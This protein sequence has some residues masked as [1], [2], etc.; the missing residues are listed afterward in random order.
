[1]LKSFIFLNK[2]MIIRYLGQTSYLPIYQAMQHF[3]EERVSTTPDEIWV[4]EHFPVYTLGMAGK[5]TH[6]LNTGDVPVYHVDRGGQVTYHGIG[7]LIVYTLLNLENYQWHIRDLVYLLE[8]AVID[9]L[10]DHNLKGERRDKA[11]GV[12]VDG[13]KLAA[14]GLRVRRGCTYHG[15]SLNVAMNLSPFAGINPCGYVGL[16]VTQ[17]RDL[18]I[19]ANFEQVVQQF[20]P[21]LLKQIDFTQGSTLP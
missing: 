1:M 11:P 14:L 4:L 6:L 19:T 7:Q 5:R 21:Y 2:E 20:L 10:A 9:Y 8:Q 17:L 13:R 12:Y 3:T 15:L 16:K 18:G